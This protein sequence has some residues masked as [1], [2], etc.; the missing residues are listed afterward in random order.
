MALKRSGKRALLRIFERRV[1]A[2]VPHRAYA[3]NFPRFGLAKLSGSESQI[4]RSGTAGDRRSRE[5]AGAGA[6]LSFCIAS[7]HGEGNAPR[8]ARG[9]LLAHSVA[10]S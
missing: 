10:K 1:V 8:C 9:D 3:A 4:R 2:A 6:G 7:A 5:S